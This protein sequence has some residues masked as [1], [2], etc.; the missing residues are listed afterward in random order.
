MMKRYPDICVGYRMSSGFQSQLDRQGGWIS[1]GYL[2]PGSRHH[3][4]DDRKLSLR[5]D[6]EAD[7]VVSIHRHWIAASGIRGGMAFEADFGQ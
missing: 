1:E 5:A 7:A 3:R 4:N 2:R 6:L